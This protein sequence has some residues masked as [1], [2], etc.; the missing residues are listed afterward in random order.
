MKV[1]KVIGV[2]TLLTLSAVVKGA[3]VALVQ[4]ILLTLGSAFYALD[5]DV[6]PA[7]NINLLGWL[8][9]NGILKEKSQPDIVEDNEV[10]SL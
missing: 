4:P 10:E 8:K 7:I 2:L 6:T 5:Q 9:L 1:L 3:W